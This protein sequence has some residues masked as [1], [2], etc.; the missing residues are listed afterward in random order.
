MNFVRVAPMS[1]VNI[2]RDSNNRRFIG[3]G[4]SVVVACGSVSVLSDTSFF[5]RRL[6]RKCTAGVSKSPY[7]SV[8]TAVSLEKSS[9]NIGSSEGNAVLGEERTGGWFRVGEL[10]CDSITIS[11]RFNISQRLEGFLI[12]VLS[13]NLQTKQ[14]KTYPTN[15]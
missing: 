3:V 13:E 8:E 6:R 15:A 2:R 7:P 5:E 10:I 4:S 9:T 12:I 11:I 14:T 1:I